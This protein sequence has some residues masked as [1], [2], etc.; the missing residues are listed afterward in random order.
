MNLPMGELEKTWRELSSDKAWEA[1]EQVLAV[2]DIKILHI[3]VIAPTPQQFEVYTASVWRAIDE[4]DIICHDMTLKVDAIDAHEVARVA[5]EERERARRSRTIPTP[6]ALAENRPLTP[7][8]YTTQF[9]TV[10]L[11]NGRGTENSEEERELTEKLLVDETEVLEARPPATRPPP[12]SRSQ[13]EV[14]KAKVVVAEKYRFRKENM[15]VVDEKNGFDKEGGGEQQPPQKHQPMAPPPPPASPQPLALGQQQP[16][17]SYTRRGLGS[18]QLL[19]KMLSFR[20]TGCSAPR[21]M[22]SSSRRGSNISQ[23]GNCSS[24]SS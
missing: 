24:D 22:C 10:P 7:A 5:G 19:F 23:M 16:E 21:R 14:L 9:V 17:V 8:A 3:P 1:W 6:S 4:D 15:V 18:K 11:L 2:R 20:E 12:P 13:E